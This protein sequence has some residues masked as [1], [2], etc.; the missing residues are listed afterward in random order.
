MIEKYELLT[1]V[2]T[3][4]NLKIITLSE[5]RHL[6]KYIQN[7]ER[8]KPINPKSKKKKLRRVWV[9]GLT[10]KGGWGQ[11]EVDSHILMG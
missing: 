5:R 9:Q 10:G 6:K 4:V 8:A 7:T 11:R 3:W 2:N 1:N